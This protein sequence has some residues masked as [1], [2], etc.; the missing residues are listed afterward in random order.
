MKSNLPPGV[1]ECDIPGNRPEDVEWE[2]VLDWICD[3]KISARTLQGLVM[4][5]CKRTKNPPRKEPPLK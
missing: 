4:G 3:T 1:M 2:Q 5:W